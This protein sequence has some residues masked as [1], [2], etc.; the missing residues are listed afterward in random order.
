MKKALSFALLLALV[1]SLLLPHAAL[2]DE[3]PVKGIFDALLAEGS[4]YMNTKAIYQEY[5]P[6]TYEETLEENGFT[7]TASKSGGMFDGSWTFTRDGNDLTATFG[8]EDWNGSAMLMHV[9]QATADYYGQN[10]TLVMG[11]INGTNA[12]GM[13]TSGLKMER[14]EANGTMT[15]RLDISGP[16]TMEGL[17]DLHITEE[18]LYTLGVSQLM[19]ES[20]ISTSVSLGRVITLVNGTKDDCTILLGE[21]EKLDEYAIEAFQSL[22]AYL[23]PTGWEEISAKLTGMTNMTEDN[24]TLIA[25]ADE[26]QVLEI[27]EDPSEGYV[28]AILRIGGTAE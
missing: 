8:S 11:Y 28:Y 13:E 2:A 23:Q 6:V 27:Y 9:I 21:Y 17:D 1:L 15:V 18:A 19:P 22:L 24:F 14:D 12:L 7:I 3:D 20:N 26:A 5:Y 10:S 16:F 25:P 4:S